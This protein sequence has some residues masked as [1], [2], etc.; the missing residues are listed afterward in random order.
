MLSCKQASQLVSQSLEHPLNRRE[1]IALRMHLWLC[2]YCRRFS[3]QIQTLRVMLRRNI[4]E[5]ENDRHITLPAETKQTI[6][7]LINHQS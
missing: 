2:R 3:Q 1:R 6:A 4:L 7:N 5:I